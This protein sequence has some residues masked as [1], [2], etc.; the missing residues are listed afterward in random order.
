MAAD[1]GIV[2]QQCDIAESL[3]DGRL[4][5]LNVIEIA[6]VDAEGSHVARP[7]GRRAELRGGSS[8]SQLASA[9]QT[10]MASAANLAEAA[11]PMP[12]AAP[13]TTATRFAASA[14]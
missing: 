11:R 2:H 5:A 4:E 10:F 8:T 7:R 13:V 1:A 12:L 6:D 14:G 9:M 3:V